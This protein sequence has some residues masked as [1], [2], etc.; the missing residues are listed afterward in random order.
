MQSLKCVVER[1]S[2]TSEWGVPK[3]RVKHLPVDFESGSTGNSGE[4]LRSDDAAGCFRSRLRRQ[5]Y[6]A[7]ASFGAG[8]VSH[9][10]RFESTVPTTPL[11]LS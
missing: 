6:K 8:Q 9:D 10:A 11:T 2:G 4:Q 3:H 1:P 7:A 5:V